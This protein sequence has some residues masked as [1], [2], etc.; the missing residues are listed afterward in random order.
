MTLTKFHQEVAQATLEDVMQSLRQYAD[1]FGMTGN[2]D[3][4]AALAALAGWLDNYDR[5]VATLEAWKVAVT[6]GC[7]ASRQADL[8]VCDRRW[9]D[10]PDW[11]AA[12]S[13]AGKH[14]AQ[15]PSR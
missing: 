15:E 1:M 3:L 5:G 7:E 13:I 6:A 8:A 10:D 2:Y 4:T 14:L 12:L 11:Q 9:Y